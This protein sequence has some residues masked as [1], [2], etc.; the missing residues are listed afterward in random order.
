MA[1]RRA[2]TWEFPGCKEPEAIPAHPPRDAGRRGSII[3]S[4]S[5]CGAN[6][7][8]QVQLLQRNE[9]TMPSA[10]FPEGCGDRPSPHMGPWG[11]ERRVRP[12]RRT[13]PRRV[14]QGNGNIPTLLGLRDV[15]VA[16]G[17]YRGSPRKRSRERAAPAAFRPP[18]YRALRQCSA[19]DGK[20]QD[21][22]HHQGDVQAPGQARFHSGA[23]R[24]RPM[25]LGKRT[26]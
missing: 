20:P 22:R 18:P 21:C 1:I 8:Y 24:R 5:A 6:T 14:W 10:A 12:R 16:F 19:F 7:I 25:P 13:G 11:V 2:P 17:R 3:A 23:H 9:A 15:R 26:A 4:A